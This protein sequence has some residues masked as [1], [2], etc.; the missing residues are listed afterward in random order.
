M[1]HSHPFPAFS[2]SK[3]MGETPKSSFFT[4]VN[5]HKSTISMAMFIYLNPW[6]CSKQRTRRFRSALAQRHAMPR[7]QEQ[8]HGT[9]GAQHCVQLC[10]ELLTLQKQVDF[11]GSRWWLTYPSEKYESQWK[12]MMTSHI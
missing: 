5:Q 2:T 1:D 12:N 3:K 7:G 6:R 11:L 4:W 10:D 9:A 8:L